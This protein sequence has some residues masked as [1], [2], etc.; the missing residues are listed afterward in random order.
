MRTTLL[1]ILFTALCALPFLGEAAETVLGGLRP[2]P[3]A[4]GAAPEIELS[5]RPDEDGLR[6]PAT[7]STRFGSVTLGNGDD[8][9]ISLAFE[10]TETPQL[11]IDCNNNESLIDDGAPDATDRYSFDSYSW[12]RTLQVS[13]TW[14]GQSYEAPY[15][16][17]ISAIR[18]GEEWSLFI[19]SFC[20]KEGR[21]LLGQTPTAIW[22][23][24]MNT[25]GLFDD[26]DE[27]L[28][29]IDTNG[30]GEPAL[31]YSGPEQYPPQAPWAEMGQFQ[32]DGVTYAVKEVSPDRGFLSVSEAEVQ[33][34]PLSSVIVGQPAPAFTAT[35]LQGGSL[36][37]GVPVGTARDSVLHARRVSRRQHPMRERSDVRSLARPRRAT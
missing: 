4:I 21:L 32:L 9:I 20:L 15:I 13:Y 27:R 24:D 5:S 36:L 19:G 16:L 29:I 22:L 8:P 6:F 28:L 12:I 37:I 34:E 2:W 35:S 3:S 31:D 14:N 17:R 23:G 26:A 7:D 25:D 33:A 1:F 11:W 10:G 30:D 18:H